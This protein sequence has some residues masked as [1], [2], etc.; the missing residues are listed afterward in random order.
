MFRGRSRRTAQPSPRDV[1]RAASGS[2]HARLEAARVALA[3][4]AYELARELAADAPGSADA[5]ATLA[6]ELAL[7]FG[8]RD[9]ARAVA[10]RCQ[11]I[12]T[13]TDRGAGLL[14]LV[15]VGERRYRLPSG[16]VH[17]L[18]V[19]RGLADGTLSASAALSTIYA[20][21]A[22]VLRDSELHVLAASAHGAAGRQDMD[23]RLAFN[24]YLRVR[25]AGAIAAVRDAS[26]YL[27]GVRLRP[28]APVVR[29]PRVSVV[30]ASYR[31]AAT[32]GYAV[33]SILEQSYR[34][35]EL[36]VCDDASDDD[37]AAVLERYRNDP[38][39][40][41]FSSSSNQGTYNIRNHMLA[42]ATGELVTFHDADDLALPRR[43]ELQVATMGRSGVIACVGNWLRLRPNGDAVVFHDQRAER[44]SVVSLMVRRSAVGTYRRARFGAD[45][46]KLQAL[47][48]QHGAGAVAR[49]RKPLVLGLW[50]S[51]SLT[52]GVGGE[53]LEDGYRS[54]ARRRYS[55]LLFM[56]DALGSDG[57][58]DD[59]IDR[60]LAADDNLLEPA[61]VTPL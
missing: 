50:S 46:D 13:A 15:S 29:G 5:R 26:P 31:A 51:R 35:L 23:G 37:T 21:A 24:R 14:E 6:I 54:P 39:V 61:A 55:E 3:G 59:E 32:V 9:E 33:E 16:K 60:A 18:A 44:L 58:G 25:R 17:K 19:A 49:I 45:L 52:R 48:R 4:G 30:M 11:P 12:L 40:R 57:P 8:E 36:L 38:R 7:A 2:A 27:A 34:N 56:R 42:R 53:A 43:L 22:E 10:E 28:V 41:L 20:R 1:V 47:R